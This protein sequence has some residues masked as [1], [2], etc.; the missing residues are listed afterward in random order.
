MQVSK[1]AIWPTV[2]PLQTI[3]FFSTQRSMSGARTQT[4]DRN[5]LCFFCRQSLSK[6]AECP[7]NRVTVAWSSSWNIMAK[8]GKLSF[9]NQTWQ[10]KICYLYKF[11]GSFPLKRVFPIAIFDLLR[12]TLLHVFLWHAPVAQFLLYVDAS[13]IP[14]ASLQM[15][16]TK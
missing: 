1:C 9:G 5:V 6:F 12:G 2:S 14:H 8:L 15:T 7:W 10:W 3:F 4:L 16:N 11:R 13:E